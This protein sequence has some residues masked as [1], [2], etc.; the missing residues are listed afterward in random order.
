MQ[1]PVVPGLLVHRVLNASPQRV[2][3]AWT[4]PALAQKFLSPGE[5]QIAEI[6]LEVRV[7]GSYRIVMQK[8]GGER[9]VVG[10]VYREVVPERRLVMTW[11]WEEDD[12]NDEYDTLLTVEFAPHGNGTALT[13]RHDRFAKP[14]SRDNHE[15]GWNLILDKMENLT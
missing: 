12:P 14:E 13:L 15:H 11:R 4:D 7:G 2:Y 9:L 1:S 8:P 5:V 6:S 3:Q 10:G